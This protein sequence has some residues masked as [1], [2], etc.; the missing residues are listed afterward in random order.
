MTTEL[1]GATPALE[2]AV[3]PDGL[4]LIRLRSEDLRI[5]AV[6]GPDARVRARDGRSL[7]GYAIERGERRLELRSGHGRRRDLEVEIPATASVVVE[8]SSADIRVDGL[9]G[10]QRYR[11][12]SGDLELRNV[13]GTIVAEAMSGDVDILADGPVRIDVRTVSG[14]IA[15]RAGAIGLLRAGTTSGDLRV[16]G[17]FDG[18]GPFAVETVSGDAT[19]APAGD[20]RVEVRTITGDIRSDAPSR[21]EESD[22][23]RFLVLGSGGP[24]MT[25]RST[26]G[27][28]RIVRAMPL[29]PEAPLEPTVPPAGA[30]APAPA[31]SPDP[32]VAA[33]AVRLDV[34]RALERGDI[35]VAEAGRRLEALDG[36]EPSDVVAPTRDRHAPLGRPGTPEE[37]HRA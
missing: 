5:R 18:E 1:T 22:G 35:D 4:V 26:S 27:D 8:G 15:V 23:R 31:P 20:L 28:L 29:R 9:A 30:I 21:L 16:A 19:I 6:A 32:D 17:R 24:S 36:G 7:D 3:G 13:C 34:L 14:D 2:H 11:S 25:F 10:E 37:M 12:L 33:D